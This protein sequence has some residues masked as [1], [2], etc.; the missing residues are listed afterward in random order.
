MLGAQSLPES[1][2]GILEQVQ[3]DRND[4]CR[5]TASEQALGTLSSEDITAGIKIFQDRSPRLTGELNRMSK[6]VLVARCG[7]D[8]NE[9]GVKCLLAAASPGLRTSG[10]FCLVFYF[11]CASCK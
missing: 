3:Q 9:R 2:G 10:D 4:I 5:G 1:R 6:L 7:Y 8:E 11:C